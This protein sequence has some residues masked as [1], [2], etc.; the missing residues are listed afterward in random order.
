MFGAGEDVPITPDLLRVL[1]ADEDTTR[2]YLRAQSAFRC[3]SFLHQGKRIRPSE[4]PEELREQFKNI[5]RNH[6]YAAEVGA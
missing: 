4:M 5:I 3:S 1:L 2:P 6:R